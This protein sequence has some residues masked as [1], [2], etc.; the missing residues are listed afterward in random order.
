MDFL[1]CFLIF[2]LVIGGFVGFLWQGLFTKWYTKLAV[3]LSCICIFGLVSSIGITNQ[4]KADID[5]WNNGYCQC[6]THWKLVDIVYA[7]F[8]GY[9]YYYQCDNCFNIIRITSKMGN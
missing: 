4:A 3:V 5:S 1:I 7:K 6:G 2:G 9:S 8:D